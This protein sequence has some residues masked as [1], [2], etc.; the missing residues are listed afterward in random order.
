MFHERL[1]SLQRNASAYA[2]STNP[3]EAARVAL[4]EEQKKYTKLLHAWLTRKARESK[5]PMLQAGLRIARAIEESN[6]LKRFEV[7]SLLFLSLR[8]V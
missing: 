3:P 7:S 1:G 4:K 8:W 5:D 6:D 2:A